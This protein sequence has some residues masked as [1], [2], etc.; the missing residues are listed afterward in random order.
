MGMLRFA[1]AVMWVEH[2]VLGLPLSN[3]IVEPDEQLGRLILN[4]ILEGGNFGHH[5]Q[6]YNGHRGFYYRGMA[7]AKRDLRL[8]KMAPRECVA[9]LLSKSRT[10]VR[11]AV[12][13]CKNK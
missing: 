2:E 13:K 12:K 10:A 5:T 8:F 1:K 9:R 3:C 7:E 4:D 6:R 11:Y